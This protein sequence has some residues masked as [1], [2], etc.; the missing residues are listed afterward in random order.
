MTD[1]LIALTKVRRSMSIRMKGSMLRGHRIRANRHRVGSVRERAILR[2]TRQGA[3]ALAAGTP[4]LLPLI[5]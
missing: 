1:V 4:R 2:G 3:V 5:L